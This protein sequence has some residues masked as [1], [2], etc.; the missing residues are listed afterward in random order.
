MASPTAGE[1]SDGTCVMYPKCPHCKDWI[2]LSKPHVVWNGKVYHCQ[3][4]I[5]VIAATSGK[6]DAIHNLPSNP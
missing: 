1:T 4:L 3:C 5:E 2:D 6:G